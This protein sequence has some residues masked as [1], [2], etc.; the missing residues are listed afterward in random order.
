MSF[1]I[2]DK[3]RQE[4]QALQYARRMYKFI[5]LP[6]LSQAV[7]SIFRS[8]LVDSFVPDIVTSG[9]KV[10]GVVTERGL[11]CGTL[12]AFPLAFEARRAQHGMLSG[13]HIVRCG[14]SEAVSQ[15]ETEENEC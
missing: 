11:N 7:T 13:I 2:P 15:N 12:K 1:S 10:H 14:L 3:A 5:L 6:W 8:W 9:H 4:H